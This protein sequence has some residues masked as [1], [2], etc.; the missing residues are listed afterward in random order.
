[1]KARANEL[2]SR[3]GCDLADRREPADPRRDFPRRPPQSSWPRSLLAA[4]DVLALIGAPPFRPANGSGYRRHGTARMLEW[5]AAFPGGSW[6]ERWQERWQAT[7]A[8]DLPKEE[9]LQLPMQWRESTGR[10]LAPV[11]RDCYQTGLLMLVC[12]DVVRPA[13]PWMVR[14]ASNWIVTAMAAC[15]DPGGAWRSPASP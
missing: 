14:R 1:M 9:W 2:V 4:G 7:G 6:Q 8:E 11:N 10:S 12:A 15:R 5:L 3:P 13:L